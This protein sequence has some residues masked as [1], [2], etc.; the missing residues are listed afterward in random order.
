MNDYELSK[1]VRSCL[2]KHRYVS[3]QQAQET[4]NKVHKKRNIELRVYFCKQCLG[5]HL[6]STRIKNVNT[7][8]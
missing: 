2:K 4:I 6:T 7:K 1:F 8:N 5:Y 3:E